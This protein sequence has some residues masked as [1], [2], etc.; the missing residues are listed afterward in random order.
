MP[1]FCPEIGSLSTQAQSPQQ[2]KNFSFVLDTPCFMEVQALPSGAECG[3]C[4]HGL[5][6]VFFL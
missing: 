5:L 3:L 1:S 4:E 2:V 6:L